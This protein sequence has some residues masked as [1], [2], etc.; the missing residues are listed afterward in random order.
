MHLQWVYIVNLHICNTLIMF[1]LTCSV[2]GYTSR[3]TN[4]Q[5]CPASSGKLF[6]LTLIQSHWYMCHARVVL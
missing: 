5:T 2:T 6:L 3:E 4:S 1:L